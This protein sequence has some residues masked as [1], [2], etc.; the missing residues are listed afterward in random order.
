MKN[1]LKFLFPSNFL[2]KDKHK[3]DY[4][5][6]INQINRPDDSRYNIRR[7]ISEGSF[8]RYFFYRIRYLSIIF[9]LRLALHIFLVGEITHNDSLTKLDNVLLFYIAMIFME[10]V[11]WGICEK[12]RIKIRFHYFNQLESNLSHEIMKY[13]IWAIFLSALFS[14]SFIISNFFSDDRSIEA[15]ILLS[16]AFFISTS[17][18]FIISVLF[19]AINSIKR[20][21]IPI[22]IIVLHEVIPLAILFYVKGTENSY[23]YFLMLSAMISFLLNYQ[24]LLKSGMTY[25]FLENNLLKGRVKFTPRINRKNFRRNIKEYLMIGCSA[26][27]LNANSF[28]FIFSHQLNLDDEIKYLYIILATCFIYCSRWVRVFYF[29]FCDERLS[30]I[31]NFKKKLLLK[32]LMIAPLVGSTLLCVGVIFLN[33]LFNYEISRGLFLEMLFL[34]ISISLS[35]ALRYSAFAHQRY[36]LVFFSMLIEIVSFALLYEHLSINLSFAFSAF[37]VAI[38]C[39]FMIFFNRLESLKYFSNYPI[40][41]TQWKEVYLTNRGKDTKLVIMKLNNKRQDKAKIKSLMASI[42]SSINSCYISEIY[43]NN[44]YYFSNDKNLCEEN[45]LKLSRGLCYE[46]KFCALDSASKNDPRGIIRLDCE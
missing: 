40:P 18:R 24:Y 3:W 25:V 34:A 26:I 8:L 45:I 27:A 16:F 41:F 1:F 29:D 17:M 23:A 19:S 32:I 39:F 33:I 4:L 30:H 44:L 37:L 13:I 2:V 31:Q 10:S 43:N 11:W 7:Y 21:Y 5:C 46:V 6:E 12:L 35:S 22:K 9:P 36:V 28:P 15:M 20:V 38:F 42:Y 14:I